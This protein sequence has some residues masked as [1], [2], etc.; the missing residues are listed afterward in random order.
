MAKLQQV[1]IARHG[2]RIDVVDQDWRKKAENPGDPPL[3]EL[4][5]KQAHQLGLRLKKEKIDH[6]YCSPFLRTVQTAHQVANVLSLPVKV[7]YGL[8]EGLLEKLFPYGEPKMSSLKA[9]KKEMNLVS[10]EECSYHGVLPFPEQYKS[11]V[12]RVNATLAHYL[13]KHPT[14]NVLFVGHGLSVDYLAKALLPKERGK[15][16]FIPYCSLAECEREVGSDTWRH[17]SL[18]DDS[19]L[20]ARQSEEESRKQRIQWDGG[21]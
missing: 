11:V 2:E 1:F 4:G 16:W 14:E 19:F 3:T 21:S 17:V 20:D 15:N 6:I 7:E 13:K 10:L 12:A 8:S 18:W 9:L 5:F